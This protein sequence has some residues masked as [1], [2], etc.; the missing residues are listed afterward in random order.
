M[1]QTLIDNIDT[2]SG[3]QKGTAIDWE[4]ILAKY[5]REKTCITEYI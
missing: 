1:L 2:L 5:I 4:H 3:K